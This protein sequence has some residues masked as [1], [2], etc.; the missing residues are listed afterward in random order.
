[1]RFGSLALALVLCSIFPAGV[2]AEGDAVDLA[3]TADQSPI[4]AAGENV[5]SSGGSTRRVDEAVKPKK[6]GWKKLLHSVGAAIASGSYGDSESYAE[7]FPD[8]LSPPRSAA[9]PGPVNN[10]PTWVVPS[11]KGGAYNAMNPD[12]SIS[13]VLPV[14]GGGYHVLGGNGSFTSISPN[15]GSGGGY[16]VFGTNGT[17]ANMRPTPG[18][19]YAVTSPD[20]SYASMIPRSDGG[21]NVVGPDGSFTT[22]LPAGRKR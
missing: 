12:G 1:V 22:I 3:P 18:G 6:S 19:G 8:G 7:G 21:Y 13:T 9:W 14:P 5:P 10:T 11:G 2:A 20:G 17:F 16:T 4:P 15:R